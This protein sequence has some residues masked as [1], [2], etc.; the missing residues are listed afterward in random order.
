M[1]RSFWTDEANLVPIQ[2]VVKRYDLRF[3]NN[4]AGWLGQGRVLVEIES[5]GVEP[6]LVRIA[7][8]E[9]DAIRLPAVQ[10]PPS[11]WWDRI[12]RWIRS[13]HGVDVDTKPC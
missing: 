5:N 13:P 12:I 4:P 6:W 7:H 9:I 10:L 1:I 11:S 8:D 2:R 3:H